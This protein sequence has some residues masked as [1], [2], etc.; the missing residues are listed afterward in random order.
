MVK[1]IGNPLSWGASALGEAGAMIAHGAEVIGS[2]DQSPPEINR[3]A[4]AD[5]RQALRRGVQDFTH[6]RTDVMMMVAIYPLIGLMLGFVAFQQSLFALIF[7]IA[8][9]FALIGPLAATGLYAM[10]RAREQGADAGWGHAFGVIRSATFAPVM[11]LGLYLI[12]LYA[13]WLYVAAAI[14]AATVGT[15][16]PQNIAEFATLVVS[17]AEGWT[18]IWVGN[19]VGAVFAFVAL[20]TG[21]IA[22]PMLVD[23][24]VGVPVAVVTSVKV[25]MQNKRVTLVWGMVVA[26]MLLLASVP[27]FLGMIVALPILG[28]GTW[29]LYRRAVSYPKTPR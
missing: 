6:F 22:F 4:M 12:A 5:I 29:H 21:F 14:Y 20:V 23:R 27:L 16:A 24:P 10:S 13:V 26:L 3:L 28:H 2:E 9:G 11:V 15:L 25:A 8:A 18:M 17:T 1:T 19:A 7:P